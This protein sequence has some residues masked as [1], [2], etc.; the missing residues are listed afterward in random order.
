M[1]EAAFA[2][3]LASEGVEVD[4]LGVAPTP[5]VAWASAGTTVSPAR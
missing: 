5:A 4:L 3:G 2:A 1:L